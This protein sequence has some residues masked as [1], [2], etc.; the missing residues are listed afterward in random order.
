MLL[1]IMKTLASQQLIPTICGALFELSNPGI[2]FNLLHM[3]L[4][5]LIII[6]FCPESENPR[7]ALFHL[8][9]A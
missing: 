1:N 2:Q 6:Q 7:L 9:M 3:S 5:H 4:G 8:M